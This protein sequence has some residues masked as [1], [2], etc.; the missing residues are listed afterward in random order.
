M[1][2]LTKKNNKLKKN[3]IKK[4]FTTIYPKTYDRLLKLRKKEVK[5]KSFFYKK[6]RLQSLLEVFRNLGEGGV[7]KL[8][9]GSRV[10][11]S[12]HKKNF[13]SIGLLGLINSDNPPFRNSKVGFS[14]EGKLIFS[15]IQKTDKNEAYFKKILEY[16]KINVDIT[17]I[18]KYLRSGKSI[19]FSQNSKVILLVF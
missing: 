5:S 14:E 15:K 6:D 12:K 1:I 9:P 7:N 16:K 3:V 13:L 8:Y 17:C 4:Q 2:F 18:K 11:F 10:S 19:N